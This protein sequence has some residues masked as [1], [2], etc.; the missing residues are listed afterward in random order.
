MNMKRKIKR[1]LALLRG[2]GKALDISGAS[3]T[4]E[5]EHISKRSDAD[6]LHGDWSAVGRDIR[7]AMNNVKETFSANT[8]K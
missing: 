2:I 3:Y 4:R 6:A 8:G 7:V 1:A 5:K